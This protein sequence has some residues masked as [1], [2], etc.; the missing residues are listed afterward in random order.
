MVAYAEQR[1]FEKEVMDLLNREC[2]EH[3][4]DSWGQVKLPANQCPEC[5]RIALTK[6]AQK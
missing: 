2:S 4:R 5:L 6:A 3:M 1:P